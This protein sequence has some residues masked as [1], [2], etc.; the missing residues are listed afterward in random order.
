M[1][2][3]IF[4]MQFGNDDEQDMP[5]I[6]DMGNMNLGDL[7][8]G[9]EFDLSGDYDLSGMGDMSESTVS[10]AVETQVKSA[11]NEESE[12]E[13]MVSYLDSYFKIW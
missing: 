2:V 10:D 3:E 6:F 5:S 4:G 9:T 7:G 1:V 11:K 13:D 12:S 8:M